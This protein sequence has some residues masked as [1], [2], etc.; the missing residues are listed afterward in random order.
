MKARKWTGLLIC[1]AA[2]LQ[3]I[4]AEQDVLGLAGGEM[5]SG[6]LVKITESSAVFRTAMG[7]RI[8][9]PVDRITALSTRR[10][11]MVTARD[12]TVLYGRFCADAE[13]RPALRLLNGTV[14]P[15]ALETL[16]SATALPETAGAAPELTDQPISGSLS[17]GAGAGGVGEI[18]RPG[19]SGRLELGGG[20]ELPFDWGVSAEGAVRDQGDREQ[21]RGI[22]Q[23]NEGGIQPYLRGGYTRNALA[24]DGRL[25]RRAFLGL[26]LYRSLFPENARGDAAV[27]LGVGGVTERYRDRSGAEDSSDSMVGGHL[28]LRLHRYLFGNTLLTH[29]GDLFADADGTA[30]ALFTESALIRPVGERLHLRL[31]FD[32][33]YTSGLAAR[34][35]WNF[36]WGAAVGMRF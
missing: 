5:F 21:F 23:G 32:A 33:D 11:F 36:W 7:G 27:Y 34:D 8:V 18:D 12:G 22:I 2:A 17:V 14:Q 9:A 31:E 24:D 4:A 6:T 28:G 3:A 10:S 15:L 35:G 20:G 25:S 30:V 19:V 26:G 1:W 16:A 13:G 29:S